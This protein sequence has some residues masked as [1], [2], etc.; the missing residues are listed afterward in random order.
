MGS[1]NPSE[2]AIATLLDRYPRIKTGLKSTYQ[3]ANYYAFGDRTFEYELHPDV[4]LGTPEEQFGV[5]FSRNELFFGYFD[6]SP[7]NR[8][9]D[10][11][12][13]HAPRPDGDADIVLYQEA[14]RRTL[15]SSATWN[16]QQGS[17]LQWHPTRDDRILFNDVD[18]N[19]SCSDETRPIESLVTR[20]INPNGAEQKRFSMPLQSM[21]PT[22]DEFLSISYRRL[23][24]NRPDYGYEIDDGASLPSPDRD[25]L[26]QVQMDSG[27]S[28][29]LV[30]L[31][32]L[33]D[34][35]PSS[36]E[37][38]YDHHYLNH[39]LYDPTGEQAVFM[40]RW[41]DKKGRTSRLYIIN[42]DGDDRR[43]LIDN[44][45]VSHYCWLDADRLFVWGRLEG[46]GSG[47]YIVDV[48]K[49]EIDL[50]PV[51]NRYSDGHPSVSPDGRWI[52]ADTYPD[53]SRKRSLILYDLD[54]EELTTVGN[55][56]A[57]L[58]FTGEQRCDLHPR[59]SPNGTA[60]SIDS[61]HNGRRY[62]YTLDINSLIEP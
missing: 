32:E 46:Y 40:H 1:Y 36:G 19:L 14:E 54:K 3:R 15:A 12:I 22:G 44:R 16:Y 42:R 43:L 45:I 49:D 24:R 61:V 10:R 58:E 25:G 23:D 34:E 53:R 20:V 26:W 59:F 4:V 29:L 18:P 7:W 57:P 48:S 35:T 51:L 5:P 60:V 41:Q 2:R 28:E 50:V 38:Q 8:S 52:I 21:S 27:S 62:S 11:A 9:M 39:A 30:S 6:V 37:E 56:F 55:F 13:Y 33:I 31:S 47:Y 17:R